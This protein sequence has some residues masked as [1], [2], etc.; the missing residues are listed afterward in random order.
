MKDTEE[1]KAANLKKKQTQSQSPASQSTLQ[2]FDSLLS[3]D[4]LKPVPA[5]GNKSQS[6]M[7]QNTKQDVKA[8]EEQTPSLPPSKDSK[9]ATAEKRKRENMQDQSEASEKT[10]ANEKTISK[11]KEPKDPLQLA[12]KKPKYMQKDLSVSIYLQRIGTYV[13]TIIWS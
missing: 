2:K 10:Q 9:R 5:E 6:K 13:L 8:S 1:R 7:Y 3:A 12:K 11:R 4:F